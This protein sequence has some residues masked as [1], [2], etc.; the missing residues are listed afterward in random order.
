MS[1]PPVI[2]GSYDELCTEVLTYPI[3]VAFAPDFVFDLCGPKQLR[4][5]I[6]ASGVFPPN[7]LA[8]M[9]SRNAS[10]ALIDRANTFVDFFST[11]QRWYR[12]KFGRVQ[13]DWTS[14]S[15]RQSH[16]SLSPSGMMVDGSVFGFICLVCLI[17]ELV[18]RFARVNEAFCS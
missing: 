7:N 15:E 12:R 9:Y 10:R 11:A 18:L 2:L 5:A 17:L 14:S 8:F 1:N 16:S 13:K 6:I 3:S 4:I